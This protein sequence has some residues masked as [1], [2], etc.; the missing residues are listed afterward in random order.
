MTRNGEYLSSVTARP[1]LRDSDPTRWYQFLETCGSLF[2]PKA[3]AIKPLDWKEAMRY[4]L[5]NDF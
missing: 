5:K 3:I 4:A 2:T 1:S